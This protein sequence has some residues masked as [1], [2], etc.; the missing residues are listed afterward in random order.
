MH[1]D[2]HDEHA[3]EF[4]NYAHV[5]PPWLLV[6]VFAAL[7]VFTFLTVAATWYDMGHWN[8]WIAMGIATLKATLVVLYFM[9]LRYDSPFNAI[10]FLTAL[11]TLFLFISFALL[12]S[13]TYQPDIETFRSAKPG[14]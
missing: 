10:V 1:D 12:D 6:T 3:G 4:S 13:T 5:V 2:K 8:L 11:G 9:H 14:G 7:M